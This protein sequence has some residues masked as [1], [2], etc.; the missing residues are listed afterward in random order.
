MMGKFK[1]ACMV[2]HP[3]QY[4]APL[5]RRLAQE[6]DIDLTVFFWSGHSVE[7]YADQGFGGVQVK[8]DVPLLQGYRYEFL[9]IVR[10][11]KATT[12]WAPINRG[13]Y[14]SLKQ[15]K[16]DAVW[17][18][19][20]WSFNCIFVM[21]A[22]K[23][24]GIPVLERAEGTLVDHSRSFPRLA[25][26]R[27]FFSVMRQFIAGVLPIG[28]RNRDYWSHYLGPDFPSFWVPYAV[29]NAFFQSR[30]ALA[31]RSREEFRR[32][33]NLDP[34]L[35]VILY[36]S[37]LT[38]RKRCVDLIEAYLGMR[39]GANGQRPY[40]LIVGDGSERA[41]CEARVR[42]A[43]EP[44][45]RFL[46]FQNQSQLPRFFDLC[47]LF[48]L[49]SV[50]EPFGLIVNEVMNAGRAMVISDQVGCQTDLVTDGVNGRVFPARNVGALRSALEELINDP[51]K[52]REMGRRSLERIRHWSFEED[53]LGLR[54]ALNQ[55]AGLPLS[56]IQTVNRPIPRDTAAVLA[57]T[58]VP[59]Y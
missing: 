19:G 39:S 48:V 56:S 26:K 23:L 12:F 33:L 57:A 51:D 42:A 37:K 46:G 20:Y 27:L 40:L 45:A 15:G 38:E 16:F 30:S 1:L 50:H 52:R 8:W 4:Q 59:E 18:H 44:N 35:P 22:A 14:R 25:I 17:L 31:S 21:V 7:G 54:E 32:Q 11:A 41:A 53:I 47:D 10:P 9:P 24:L 36:A 3:I 5:L 43:G 34:D 49:P 2:S 6:P 28:S 55:V 58:R 13:F 29:D